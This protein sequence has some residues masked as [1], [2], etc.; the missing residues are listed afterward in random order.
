MLLTKGVNDIEK[1]LK[2]WTLGYF[3]TKCWHE[4][5]GDEEAAAKRFVGT[6]VAVTM[7]DPY[8]PLGMRTE[9]ER[10]GKTEL[11]L[12]AELGIKQWAAH[13]WADFYFI[14]VFN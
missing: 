9:K 2:D 7:R 5:K 6:A 1:R 13:W 14:F 8:L 10:L 12:L 3:K 4:V 11:G